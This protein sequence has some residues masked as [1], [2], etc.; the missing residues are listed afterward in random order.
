MD[1]PS[2]AGPNKIQSLWRGRAVRGVLEQVL[3]KEVAPP[4]MEVSKALQEA[5][6]PHDDQL[7]LL[8]LTCSIECFKV[9]GAGVYCYMRWQRFMMHT[10]LVAFAFSLPNIIYNCLG[11]RLGSPTWLTV[12]SLGNASSLNAPYGIA[13][14]LVCLT[15][16]VALFR[17]R[18]LLVESEEE[19]ERDRERESAIEERTVWLQGLPADASQEEIRDQMASYG[20]CTVTLAHANREVILRTHERQPLLERL[21]YEQAR[22]YLRRR[23]QKPRKGSARD[24]PQPAAHAAEISEL[25]RNVEQART[26]LTEHDRATAQLMRKRYDCTGDAFVT[27]DSPLEAEH[28]IRALGRPR[29][30]SHPSASSSHPGPPF[31]EMDTVMVVS[32]GGTP[33]AASLPPTLTACAAPSPSDIL[34]T[35]LATPPGERFWRQVGSTTLTLLIACLGT[36]GITFM[37][38]IQGT[39]F[40]DSFVSGWM[41]GGFAGVVLSLLKALLLAVPSILCNVFLFATTP[42]FS[43]LIERHKTF[44][45]KESTLFAKLAFFQI[46]NTVTSALCFLLSPA[47]DG[48]LGRDWYSLGGATVMTIM[49]PLGDCVLLPSLLDWL[50]IDTPIKRLIFAPRQKTQLGMDRLYLK[51]GDLYL[52]FR[53]HLACKFVAICLMFGGGL[54]MLY[55]FGALFFAYGMIVDRHNL[56]RNQTPPPRTSAKL[57]LAAHCHVLAIAIVAH[58]VM[59]VV[60][61]YHHTLDRARSWPLP[62]AMHPYIHPPSPPPAP[63][64]PPSMPNAASFVASGDPSKDAAT[65]IALAVAIASI[66]VVGAFRCTFGPEFA[67]AREQAAE[68]CYAW[69]KQKTQGPLPP[70]VT[71]PPSEHEKPEEPG[72]GHTVRPRPQGTY[73]PP[74]LSASLLATF[75]DVYVRSNSVAGS[76]ASFTHPSALA[77]A[78]NQ[79]GDM[80]SSGQIHSSAL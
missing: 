7:N 69:S 64:S 11:S 70:R 57:T 31:V 6:L 41:P 76:S 71:L 60:F 61:L 66:V 34:W 48:L 26:A 38:F 14:L 52:A 13:E 18:V 46:F 9:F 35:D 43:N 22:L 36:S 12:H 42:V 23:A 21:H 39:G 2:A 77:S 54:P 58:A 16:L 44:S 27:F 53:V 4:S 51:N 25:V 55:L 72:G 78:R 73:L 1:K 19:V 15:F 45:D 20:P 56:L 50:T 37:T 80:H 10:F 3:A 5:M 17:G 68:C 59:S 40:V 33:A 63:P 8:P 24:G 62:P 79:L 29:S 28:C 67:G 32:P 47:C 49:G 65:L 30:S 74:T 75:G